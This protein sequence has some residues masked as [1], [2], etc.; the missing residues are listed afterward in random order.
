MK[1]IMHKILLFAAAVF[2]FAAC[3]DPE[4]D[5]L[6]MVVGEWHYTTTESGVEIDVYLGLS[7][8][9]TF[10]LYQKIGEGPHYLYTGKYQF[11]GKVLT[12]VY[13]DYAPWANDYQIIRTGNTMVMTSVSNPDYSLT[14]K[15]ES[16][17][18]SVKT[19]YMPVTKADAK[20]VAPIL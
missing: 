4:A 3:T 15:K 5:K 12:G 19:H 1:K 20:T 11:D 2:A 14:Y 9:Y 16:I 8:D 10:E 6:E 7:A 18:E 17:P 13:A